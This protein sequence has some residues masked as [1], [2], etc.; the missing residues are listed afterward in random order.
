MVIPARYDSSR[1]PG[2]PLADICGMPMIQHV[3]KSARKS[4]AEDVIVATDDSRIFEVVEKFG[5]RALLTSKDHSSGTERVQEATKLLGLSSNDI[6]VNVQGDEPLIPPA[7]I[8]TVATVLKEKEEFGIA[9]LCESATKGIE[10]PNTVKVI[11]NSLGEALYFS[12]SSIPYSVNSNDYFRHIGLYAYRV[13]ALNKFV[14][15]PASIYEKSEKL[16]QLRALDF[17]LKI[18]VTVT[19]FN[20]PPGVDTPTDLDAVRALIP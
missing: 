10:N 1:L 13:N 3:Y 14:A 4:C 2:K 16:E 17:G 7:A 19:D 9:T 6:V 8:N 20:I 12:R 11:V 18:H 5:G 15:F